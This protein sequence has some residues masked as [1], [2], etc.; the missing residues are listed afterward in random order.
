M[1]YNPE[2][3]HRR[4]IRLKG[5]DYSQSAIYFITICIQD[6]KCLLGSIEDN[7]MLLSDPGN[8]VLEQWL[9]L[10]IRF[11][12]VI[13]DQFVVMPNHFHG[14]IYTTDNTLT[15]PTL[16]EIVGSFKSIVTHKYIDGINNKNW[17]PFNQRLWQRN[18][19]ERIVRN[20]LE[21][22]NIQ[23]YIQN[24]P[25]DWQTDSLYPIDRSPGRG[26]LPA[27]PP[28]QSQGRGLV[29]AQPHQ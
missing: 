6:R 29:P 22:Q 20:D 2:Q 13:I 16:G 23:Q 26:L 4:S 25:I 27:Q 3:H 18:Y 10:P 14:I 19:Y 12:S 9:E 5:F 17:A 15:K 1:A 11:P 7:R 21:L 8:L 28:N 24:N